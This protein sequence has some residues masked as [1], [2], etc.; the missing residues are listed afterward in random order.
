MNAMGH[1][2]PT[3]IGVEQDDVSG[4]ISGQIP[5]YMQM[6]SAGMAEMGAMEMPLPQN[7]L[8]MITGAGQ[9]GP[10]EMGGMF[11]T[12]KIRSGLARNDY[13]DPGPY[14]YPKGS[15]ARLWS[16]EADDAPVVRGTQSPAKPADSKSHKSRT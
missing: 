16:A 10:I 12:V 15:A 3:M 8:P 4:A 7:T 6:G 9:F 14:R 11:S 2:V 13:S 5:E 1:G